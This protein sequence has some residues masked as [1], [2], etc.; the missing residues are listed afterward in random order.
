MLDNHNDVA[1]QLCELSISLINL[2][3]IIINTYKLDV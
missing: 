1:F 2:L 3:V